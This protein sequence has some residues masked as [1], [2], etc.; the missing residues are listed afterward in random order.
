[1]SSGVTDASC[2]LLLLIT[3]VYLRIH[4]SEATFEHSRSVFPFFHIGPRGLEPLVSA[5]SDFTESSLGPT[6]SLLTFH[7][8]SGDPTSGRQAC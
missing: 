2:Q 1:M 5:T 6:F 8:A 3:F 7:V 4:R